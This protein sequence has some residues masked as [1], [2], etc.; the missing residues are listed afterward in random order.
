MK[1]F[2]VEILIVKKNVQQSTNHVLFRYLDVKIIVFVKKVTIEIVTRNVFYHQN[3]NLMS[4]HK[5]VIF[6]R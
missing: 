5:R 2:H 1:S 4:F 3:V 6:N